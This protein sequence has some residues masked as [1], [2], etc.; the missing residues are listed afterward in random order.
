ML[1]R[2]HL[3][4]GA[5]PAVGASVRLP[6]IPT[7]P[8]MLRPDHLAVG[9]LDC[10]WRADQLWARDGQGRRWGD[11]GRSWG[12]RS[13][14]RLC[15]CR[16]GCHGWSWRGNRSCL[17]HR[18]SRGYRLWQGGNRRRWRNQHGFRSDYLVA[19]AAS[20]HRTRSR[21][22]HTCCDECCDYQ[23][24]QEQAP[25]DGTASCVRPFSTN[26]IARSRSF[27]WFV[28]SEPQA[29]GLLASLRAAILAAQLV[30]FLPKLSDE[31]P[32]L[33]GAGVEALGV[34]LGCHVCLLH[35]VRKHLIVMRLSHD[36]WRGSPR[37]VQRS[38]P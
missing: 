37:E 2:Q 5:V 19:S 31:C 11:G 22:C 27:S 17:P 38:Y 10:V 23:P 32:W 25:H 13:N 15:R 34:C 33:S 8:V 16:S 24:G 14:Y 29:L 6:V 36:R 30:R 4:F 26:A 21:G 35:G 3:S 9:L 18:G 1:C 12:W 20:A 7:L 28:A